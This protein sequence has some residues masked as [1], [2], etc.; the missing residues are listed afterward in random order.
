MKVLFMAWDIYDDTETISVLSK[1][2]TGGGLVIKNL[3]EYIGRKCESYLFIGKC[4]LPE[5]K[6]GNIHIV[7]TDAEIDIQNME[8]LLDKGHLQVMSNIFSQAIDEIQPDIV[9]I[10]GLGLLAKCCIEICITKKIPYVYT[11]HLFIGVN[12]KIPGYEAHIEW[13]KELYSIPN[14]KIIAVS[15]GMK[16]KII[17]DFPKINSQNISVILNGT[18]Y[19]AQ[20]INSN[21]RE[22]YNIKNE[23]VLL[24]VGTLLKRKNQIQIVNAFQLLLQ[25]YNPKIKIL[26]CGEDKIE[27]TLQ[28]QIS[29]L[30]L[31]DYLIYVGNVSNNEMKKYY[32]IADGLIVP[33][34]AEGLS[35]AMLETIAYGLPIIM[36]SD[37]E[38]A[39]DLHDKK[40]VYFIKDRSDKSLAEAIFSWY[41]RKWDH[42][43]I[44]NYSKFFTMER[45]T[46]DYID[47]YKQILSTTNAYIEQGD[48]IRS[49]G[50]V[51]LKRL[52]K[53]DLIEGGK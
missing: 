2:C 37:S 31:E 40:V 12:Q 36:F 24:C 9:N 23:K 28:S 4:K 8:L 16:E 30:G 10:H 44:R 1:H 20:K 17:R 27:G 14:L 13:E 7:G 34:I 46:H 18:N 47:F 33:S 11:E 50:Q 19:V 49:P 38:C 22:I 26:F 53:S 42:E 5:Q 45:M 48:R 43:Y 51:L 29:K 39:Y 21:L 3:C 25:N 32:S 52:D 35:I 6:L 41:R 15:S